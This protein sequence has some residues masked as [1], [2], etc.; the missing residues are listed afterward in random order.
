MSL[1]RSP[2]ME[3]KYKE[4]RE[5][6]PVGYT[7]WNEPDIIIKEW[8]NWKLV[9]NI[10]YWDE[11]L[12]LDNLLI[13]KRQCKDFNNLSSIELKELQEITNELNAKGNYDS[14]IANF[15][16]KRSVLYW[17]HFHCVEFLKRAKMNDYFQVDIKD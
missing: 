9:K 2:E 5:S 3:Q 4:F 8:N 13:P 10:F 12:I 11:L 17:F 7:N 15:R 14:I 1:F 16:K 6:H